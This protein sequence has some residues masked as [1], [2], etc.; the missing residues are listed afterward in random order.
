MATYDATQTGVLG[1]VGT[2]GLGAGQH[3]SRAIRKEP[4]KIEVTLD[5]PKIASG[6]GT[7]LVSA[8]ILQCIDNRFKAIV[9]YSYLE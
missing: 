7:D 4:Y 6:A 3:P 2:S 8:D 1:T 5:L 9:H